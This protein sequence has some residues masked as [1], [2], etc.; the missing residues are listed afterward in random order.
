MDNKIELL[1]KIV[2][3]LSIKNKISVEEAYDTLLKAA[4]WGHH[5]WK[6]RTGGPGNWHYIYDDD[7]KLGDKHEPPAKQHKQKVDQKLKEHKESHVSAPKGSSKESKE[8]SDKPPKEPGKKY[9][10][11]H[12]AKIALAIKIKNGQKGYKIHALTDKGGGYSLVNS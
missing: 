5:K 11:L 10:T 12:E 9:A 3:A 2:K 6:E 4:Q 8:E 1:E 7:K